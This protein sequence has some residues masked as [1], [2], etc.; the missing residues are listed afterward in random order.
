MGIMDWWNRVLAKFRKEDSTP[1]PVVE[2]KAQEAPEPVPERKTSDE[3]IVQM[4]QSSVRDRGEE[5]DNPVSE[6]KDLSGGA[7]ADPA[8]CP[9]NREAETD[10]A[11]D[12][13]PDL[14]EDSGP[15]RD[16]LLWEADTDPAVEETECE[17]DGHDKE[18]T[19]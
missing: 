14:G 16:P 18:D 12:E 8:D 9:S 19:E 15:Y 2:L 5:E 10:P 7:S 3:M 17:A 11:D 1:E 6:K 13:E 4:A